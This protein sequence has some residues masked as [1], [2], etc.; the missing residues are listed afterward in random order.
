MAKQSGPRRAA[1]A[2]AP[3]PRTAT[4]EAA[5]PRGGRKPVPQA[6]RGS[7]TKPIRRRPW[8]R[9][10]AIAALVIAV[11][12]VAAVIIGAVRGGMVTTEAPVAGSLAS[13]GPIERFPDQGRQHI[14]QGASHPGYNSTPP[15]SGWH[16]AAPAP[17][18]VSAAPVPNET[19]IHNLEHGG[20][21]IQYKES[22][23]SALV[24]QLTTLA[25]SYPT[26]ILLAPYPSLS[27]RVALT[28]W[29]ARQTYGE[30]DETAMRAFIE[31]YLN[32]GPEN[33]A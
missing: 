4:K 11:A 16:Y 9:Y 27:E 6:R 25:K 14:A 29:G 13:T 20:V 28:A 18:G 32:K 8:G 19:Q 1:R 30:Y 24:A 3:A 7:V 23:D 26:K 2:G 22:S 21:I 31:R 5:A 15:T 17:W 12:I 10:A 33:A